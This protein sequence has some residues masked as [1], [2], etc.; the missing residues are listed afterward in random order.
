MIILVDEA[1]ADLGEIALYTQ[2]EWG[3]DQRN[4]YIDEIDTAFQNILNTPHLG[5]DRSEIQ[6]GVYSRFHK[7]HTIFYKFSGESLYILRILHQ[8]RDVQAV[9]EKR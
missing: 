7:Q 3:I 5:R 6:K 8:S 4:K 9:F 2:E 1:K